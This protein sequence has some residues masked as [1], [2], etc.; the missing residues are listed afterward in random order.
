MPRAARVTS[1]DRRDW[2]AMA[3]KRG[4][5][6]SKNRR[7]RIFRASRAGALPHVRS[8]QLLRRRGRA[9]RWARGRLVT[10]VKPGQE[11]PWRRPPPCDDAGS[12]RAAVPTA[13]PSWTALRF[14]RCGAS[15]SPSAR[16][17]DRSAGRPSSIAGARRWG[18]TPWSPSGKR[19][20]RGAVTSFAQAE[21]VMRRLRKSCAGHGRTPDGHGWAMR[22]AKA[23]SLL[24]DRPR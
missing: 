20:A 6:R 13:S 19:G 10:P 23:P 12:A 15:T 2:H 11:T 22:I 1:G 8:R 5:R 17:S 7:Q 4:D 3:W 21:A 9:N 14:T 24:S 16:V 18:K